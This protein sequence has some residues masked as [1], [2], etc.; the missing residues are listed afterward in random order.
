MIPFKV[1]VY[2]FYSFPV[3]SLSVSV[4]VSLTTPSLT[5]KSPTDL[6]PDAETGSV[7]ESE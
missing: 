1:P 6:L 4:S 3:E 2:T 5:L 7:T